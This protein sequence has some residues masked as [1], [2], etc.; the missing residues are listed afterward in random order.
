MTLV[1][2]FGVASLGGSRG[3]APTTHRA[4]ALTR[5]ATAVTLGKMMTTQRATETAM[6]LGPGTPLPSPETAGRLAGRAA[7]LRPVEAAAT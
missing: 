5:M 6:R 7:P 1:G 2:P 4:P 3:E